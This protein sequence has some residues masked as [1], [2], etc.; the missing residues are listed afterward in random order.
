MALRIGYEQQHADKIAGAINEALQRH[1]AAVLRY[2]NDDITGTTTPLHVQTMPLSMSQA[3]AMIVQCGTQFG[4]KRQ[5]STSAHVDA[6]KGG[7]NG[8]QA[9]N[10]ESR[11]VEEKC[12]SGESSFMSSVDGDGDEYGVDTEQ[13]ENAE[14]GMVEQKCVWSKVGIVPNA[15]GCVETDFDNEQAENAESGMVEEKCVWSKVGILPNADGCSEADVDIEQAK[16][17]E[18]GW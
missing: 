1:R 17:A 11:L 12:V 4:F 3:R 7:A 10:A 13:A 6:K 15:D 8:E 16:S 5:G 9:E 18:S 2:L 14:S